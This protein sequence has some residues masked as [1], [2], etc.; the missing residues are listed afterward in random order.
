M[1]EASASQAGVGGDAAVAQRRVP[2]GEEEADDGRDGE[3]GMDP[4]GAGRLKSES[5]LGDNV[6]RYSFT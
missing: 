4:Q 2:A 5:K 3:E 6:G 1:I